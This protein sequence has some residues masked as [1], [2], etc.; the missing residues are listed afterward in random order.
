LSSIHN[1]G[2]SRFC[3]SSGFSNEKFP[4]FAILTAQFFFCVFSSYTMPALSPPKASGTGTEILPQNQKQPSVKHRYWTN[5]Q[6][7]T[8]FSGK[9]RK[10]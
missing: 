4:D 3:H 1:K 9:I 2:I 7:Q 5:L 8:L 10:K 6:V